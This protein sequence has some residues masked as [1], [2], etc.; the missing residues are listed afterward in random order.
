MKIVNDN[1]EK[2]KE[3]LEVQKKKRKHGGGTGD[4]FSRRRNGLTDNI[5]LHSW[6]QV[7]MCISCFASFMP[8]FDEFRNEYA[9]TIESDENDVKG[10]ESR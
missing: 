10:L 8:A 1:L 9:E 5:H 4:G 7:T 3:L 2:L 6:K